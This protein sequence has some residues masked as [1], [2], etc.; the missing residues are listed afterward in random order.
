MTNPPAAS[1]RRELI[2]YLT[3]GDHLGQQCATF[4]AQARDR[5]GPTTAQTYPPHVT[6]TGFFHRELGSAAAVVDTMQSAISEAG[7]VPGGAVEVVGQRVSEEWVGLEIRSAWAKQV[8][9]TL[10]ASAQLNPGDDALR[11]KDWLH[12]SL[13]YGDHPP[14]TSIEAYGRLASETVDPSAPAAWRIS[15][16]ERCVDGSWVDHGPPA[17]LPR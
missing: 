5:F 17:Q 6:L 12:L 3:P 9:E 1:D 10:V 15:V 13:A 7:P 2:V 4:F 11:P 14:E 16:W 8:V